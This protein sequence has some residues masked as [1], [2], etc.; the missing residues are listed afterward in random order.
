VTFVQ[1]LEPRA[2]GRYFG[3]DVALYPDQLA[4]LDRFYLEYNILPQWSD[5]PIV[6]FVGHLQRHSG[7]MGGGEQYMYINTDGHVQL[8]PFCKGEPVSAL[9]LEVQDVMDL[10]STQ[11]CQPFRMHREMLVT[12]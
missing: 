10:L 5:Y 4:L 9:S 3:Q 8:C 1:L 11:T 7:C 6:S 2:E 12:T